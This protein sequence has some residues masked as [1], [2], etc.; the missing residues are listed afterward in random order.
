MEPQPPALVLG[1]T[2]AGSVGG[3]RRRRGVEVVRRRSGGGAVLLEPGAVLWVDVILPAGDPL[4]VDD[5][6][7]PSYW[8]G[9][10][11]AAALAACGVAGATRAPR[12]D[13]A[14]RSGRASC[15]SPGWGPAR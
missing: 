14:H 5:V 15:A 8:L 4:W 12:P 3:G 11:W 9:E 10:A 13:G 7:A 1:S 2:Q 6:G